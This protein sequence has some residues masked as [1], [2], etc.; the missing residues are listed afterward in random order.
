MEPRDLQP[1]VIDRLVVEHEDAGRRVVEFLATARALLLRPSVGPRVGQGVAYCVREAL[2]SIT[3]LGGTGDL[4]RWRELSRRAVDAKTRYERAQELPETADDAPKALTDL[5][6]TVRDIEEYHQSEGRRRQRLIASIVDRTG[7][8]PHQAGERIVSEF[9]DVLELANGAV[10]ANAEFTDPSALYDRAI[11]VLVSLYEPPATRFEELETLA[12]VADPGDDAVARLRAHVIPPPHLRRFLQALRSTR[13]LEV[14]TETGI[15]DPPTGRA[16]WPG[17]AAVE[18]LVSIDPTGLVAWLECLY[19]RCRNNDAQ[20]WQIMRAAHDVGQAADDLV[21]RILAEHV[22]NSAVRDLALSILLHRPASDTLVQ[23][24]ADHLLNDRGDNL[25]AVQQVAG[26]VVR[27]IDVENGSSRLRLLTLK[28]K[29]PGPEAVQ[30]QWQW[31]TF[32][33]RGSIADRSIADAH[34]RI[35]VLIAAVAA[36]A[37]AVRDAAGTDAVLGGLERLPTEL[38]GRM[39][40]WLL[41]TDPATEPVMMAAELSASIAVR[42]PCADDLTMLDRVVEALPPEEYLPGWTQALGPAPVNEQVGEMISDARMGPAWFRAYAWLGILPEGVRGAWAAP[43]AVLCQAFGEPSR[44][45]LVARQPV[46]GGAMKSPFEVGELAAME[47]RDAAS[48]I[49]RW[50]PDPEQFMVGPRELARTVQAVVAADPARWLANPIEIATALREP[51][52]ID[53]YISGATD[54]VRAEATVDAA[55]LMDLVDLVQCDPWP[56]TAMGSPEWDYDADW[57]SCRDAAIRLLRAM[58]DKSVGYAGRDDRAWVTI[59]AATS[60]PPDLTPTIDGDPLTAAINHPPTKALEAAISFLAFQIRANSSSPPDV[61]EHL[62]RLLAVG[63]A[64]G[65]SIRAIIASRLGYLVNAVPG[66]VNAVEPTLLGDAAPEGLAQLTIDLAVRWGGPNRWLLEHHRSMVYDAVKRGVNNALKHV[67]IG[68][69]WQCA[70]YSFDQ[71]LDFLD[72]TPGR[73]SD[74]GEAL[75]RMLREAPADLVAPAVALWAPVLQSS[76]KRSLRGF[77]WFSEVSAIDDCEWSDLTLRTMR[78]G[79]G[80]IAWSHGIAKRIAGMDPTRTT[81]AILDDLIR[82][83]ENEWDGHSSA[84]VASETL[85]RA[86]RLRDT[87][88]YRRLHTALAERGPLA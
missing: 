22:A 64:H 88:E 74:A 15:L 7:G 58:A 5:L 79:S 61:L 11:T 36:A 60:G 48:T 80:P 54:A 65:A 43:F 76:S 39:R 34:T 70:G 12:T 56:A 52:H 84:E 62:E 8:K 75:G 47:P 77:G 16:P 68:Y 67:L 27:G 78:A 41:A 2:G 20:V 28:L 53:H 37:A 21:C 19:A 6:G 25:W 51:I 1:E 35:D 83:P 86:E 13:W 4:G 59:R 38:L 66:W 33:E 87:V 46:E 82:R 69:L 14:L 18:V 26:A 71:T 23:D 3:A 24:I 57:S 50:R 31:L 44:D 81:L 73:V 42:G 72:S 45:A 10:H 40:S 85:Q 17:F 55:R 30:W 29:S 63:G 32:A 9:L 49:G